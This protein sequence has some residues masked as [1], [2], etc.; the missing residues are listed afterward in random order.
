MFLLSAISRFCLSSSACASAS[1]RIFSTSSSGLSEEEVEKMRKEAEAH[2]EEDK[3]KREIAESKNIADNLIYTAEKT[4]KDLGDKA[5][6]KHKRTVED[7]VIA[8]RGA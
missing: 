8:I 6:P 4:L 2:A 5:N 1:L 7:D 3:Q